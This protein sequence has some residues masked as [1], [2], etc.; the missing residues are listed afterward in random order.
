[1][2]RICI[3]GGGFGGLYTALELARLPWTEQ[4]EIVLIDRSDRFLFTPLLY[5]LVTGELQTWEI[6]PPFL[7][8]LAGTNIQ[9]LQGNVTGVDIA[10]RCIHL[11][12][13]DSPASLNFD[14]LVL[15]IGGET[16]MNLVPGAAEYAI[17]FRTLAD[18]ARLESRLQQLEKSDREKIRVAI[19]GAGASGVELACKIA[20][21]LKSRGRV[22]LIER[23]SVILANS[24]PANRVAAE[25]ALITR[26]I[27]TDLSTSVSQVMESEITLDYSSGS[28][29]LPVDMMMWMVGNSISKL[30]HSLELP[31]NQRNGRVIVESTLQVKGYPEIYAIGDIAECYDADGV[32][33]PATAQV[34]YQQSQYCARNIWI[35][36]TQSYPLVPFRYLA[37]GEFMSLGTDNAS[38]AFLNKFGLEGLP[39]IFF[40]RFAY[41]L[42]MP[43]FQHQLKVGFNWLSRP[44]LELVKKQ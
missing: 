40:R 13:S 9:F 24:P 29:T 3:L 42:R 32:L 30:A 4:P 8:L 39:A 20:D 15:S 12:V 21:R 37:L 34:A 5:E 7:E 33:V 41:L 26:G 43:T 38:L 19:A 18:V 23:D 10:T 11:T 27:W 36:L 6:A 1:M 22:R 35:S 31:H 2:T 14:R 16:S 25:R 44:V 28:D 17:P